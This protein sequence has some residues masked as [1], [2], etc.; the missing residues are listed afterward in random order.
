MAQAPTQEEQLEYAKSLRHLEAGWTPALRETYFEWFPRAGGYRGGA[1]F[2]GYVGRIKADAIATL[3]PGEKVQLQP[4][5]DAAPALSSPQETMQALLGPR[6]VVRQWTLAELVPLVE[7]STREPDLE[8]GRRMFAGVGCFA[9]HRFANEG[10]AIGPD[11]TGA[12]GRFST[13]DLL[14]AIVTPDE[15]VSDL[16]RQVTILTNDGEIIN[17][18]I[19]YLRADTIQVM[20]DMYNPGETIKVDRR[21]VEAMRESPLSPMPSG[22]VDVLELEEIVDLVAFL[23]SFGQTAGTGADH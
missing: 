21:E 19:V 11:L 22:L 4:V 13:R 6:S 10:G 12:G 3:T 17:G 18:R 8:R 15:T 2:A 1:S 14:K 23:R 16:H 5:I 9:C 7:T 20:P